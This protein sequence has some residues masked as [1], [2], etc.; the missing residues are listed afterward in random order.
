ME[1]DHKIS[2]KD[3]AEKDK[4]EL[5]PAKRSARRPSTPETADA[6][7]DETHVAEAQ[8][9]RASS[10][11]DAGG[12]ERAQTLGMYKELVPG[13]R[14]VRDPRTRRAACRGQPE[15]QFE[16]HPRDEGRRR[17]PPATI[18]W[19]TSWDK[20]MRTTRT[21]TPRSG[22]TGPTGLGTFDRLL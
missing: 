20:T 16:T 13:L 14:F 3:M 12:R 15:S 8:P 17:R 4:D 21:A 2:L 1:Q 19:P 5:I 18:R 7:D 22:R 10:P 6:A 11:P 9:E